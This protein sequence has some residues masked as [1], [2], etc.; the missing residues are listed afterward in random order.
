M[1]K[2]PKMIIITH[3]FPFGNAEKTFLQ[4]EVN[5]LNN[6]FSIDYISRNIDDLQTGII[7]NNSQVYRYSPS[8]DYN[9]FSLLCKTIMS[10]DFWKEVKYLLYNRKDFLKCFKQTLTIYMRTYHFSLFLKKIRNNYEEEKIIWYTYW[11]GYETYA[12]K[13]VK[14]I[15]DIVISRTHGG[16]L[17]LKKDNNY[18]QPYKDITNECI[19]CLYFISED[20]YRY[21]QNTFK[22]LKNSQLYI[23]KLGTNKTNFFT[24]FSNDNSIH[25]ITLSRLFWVKRIDKLIDTLADI[26]KLKIKWTHIG[27]GE[28]YQNL[29]E[30]A[31][32][33]LNY[34]SNIKY[35]FLGNLTNDEVFEYLKN[36]EIDLLVNTS[37]SEGLPVSIMEAMSCGI[38][39]LAVSVGGIPEIVVDGVNGYIISRD[40][41]SEEFENK[42]KIYVNSSQEIRKRLHINAYKMWENNYNAEKNHYFFAMN[43]LEK[44]GDKNE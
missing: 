28:L 3:S 33:K 10:K 4:P 18:Y 2:K 36:N 40:F 7:H 26:E 38:P 30:K 22:K 25:I 32:K 31:Y 43:I 37:Y 20:G 5:V 44:Y 6:Y 17:Y 12:C 27:G 8:R 41:T 16:D 11:N 42:L 34:K 15:N 29:L 1:F 14:K 39:V 13:K 21:Y 19:D 23:S 24:K 35:E 9:I